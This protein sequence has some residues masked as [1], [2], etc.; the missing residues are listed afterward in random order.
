MSLNIV[1]NHW[2][3]YSQI[4]ALL[5]K[6]SNN[7]QDYLVADAITKDNLQSIQSINSVLNIISSHPTHTTVV[8]PINLG[9]IINRVWAGEHWVGLV[10][11]RIDGSFKAIYADSL[12]G[13]L[14]NALPD[15]KQIL[16]N[17]NILNID[18]IVDIAQQTND[19]DC[20]PWTVLNLD[21]IARVGTL[22]QFKNN[23]FKRRNNN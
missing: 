12:A 3:D 16:I 2:Y 15:L 23:N 4:D 11:I 17:Q 14:D 10:I 20:G 19:Y 9:N 6:Y 8:I 5:K 18:E 1:R 21:S 13:K 22:P 7:Q